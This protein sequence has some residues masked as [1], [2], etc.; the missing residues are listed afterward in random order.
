MVPGVDQRVLRR[1]FGRR[2]EAGE[3]PRE[4]IGASVQDFVR[5]L[6]LLEEVVI[7][8]A[9]V[10]RVPPEGRELLRRQ[11]ERL[12]ARA[13]PRAR[14]GRTVAVLRTAASLGPDLARP[15]VVVDGRV[16]VIDS[17]MADGRRRVSAAHG[18]AT[19]H[20]ELMTV[21]AHH[22]G[23]VLA[24]RLFAYSIDLP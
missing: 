11:V 21:H 14:R 2:V 24:G 15:L 7:L 18:S 8:A 4:D 20:A 5:L 19:P 6:L 22:G 23:G 12:H 3:H 13:A 16:D 10:V 9:V 17:I 1:R